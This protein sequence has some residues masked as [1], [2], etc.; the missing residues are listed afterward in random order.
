MI[1]IESNSVKLSNDT[2]VGY[3]GKNQLKEVKC[4]CAGAKE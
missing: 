2:S 1:I 3:I 4:M